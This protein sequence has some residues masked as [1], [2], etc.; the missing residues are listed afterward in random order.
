MKL[1]LLLP[2]N[3]FCNVPFIGVELPRFP[4][5]SANVG[6]MSAVTRENSWN[7]LDR[8]SRHRR[9]NFKQEKSFVHKEFFWRL[10]KKKWKRRCK[11]T[12]P[13]SRK[14]SANGPPTVNQCFIFPLRYKWCITAR[15]IK[16]ASGEAR[17]NCANN[18]NWLTAI[19]PS[20][21][22]KSFLIYKA[23]EWLV[24]CETL[25]WWENLLCADGNVCWTFKFKAIVAN[26]EFFIFHSE[27]WGNSWK[28]FWR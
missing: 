7:S 21:N 25:L 9:G 1:L 4:K 27:F 6:L 28:F 5:S 11:Q 16:T 26:P 2:L 13:R 18:A 20:Q 23:L 15:L 17:K 3:A 24:C 10:N 12:A 14:K 22:T 8:S 19:S